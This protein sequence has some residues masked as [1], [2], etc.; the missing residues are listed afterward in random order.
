MA[1]LPTNAAVCLRAC[2]QVPSLVY[3]PRFPRTRRIRWRY[4][5]RK[6]LEAFCCGMLQYLLFKQFILPPLK[7]PSKIEGLGPLGDVVAMVFDL[8]KL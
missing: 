4:V 6:L 1:T 5:A 2:L 3:E 8:M 7:N